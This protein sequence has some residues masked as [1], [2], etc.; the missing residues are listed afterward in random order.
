MALKNLFA[1]GIGFGAPH[2]IVT[3]GFGAEVVPVVVVEELKGG[4]RIYD[5]DD[6]EQK[7]KTRKLR[8]KERDDLDKM[9]AV[10]AVPRYIAP[11]PAP[12]KVTKRV[13]PP[14]VAPEPPALVVPSPDR[15]T[16]AKQFLALD[17]LD[18]FLAE[19]ERTAN[20]NARAVE[21]AH[22]KAKQYARFLEQEQQRIAREALAAEAA[23]RVAEEARIAL[24]ARMVEEARF[25]EIARIQQEQEDELMTMLLM[26][27]HMGVLE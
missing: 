9:L 11:K 10:N 15:V 24:E 26:S 18:D 16:A 27:A 13:A 12:A 8:K 20:E 17:A 4:R 7:V 2:W 19:R 14:V 25:A 1:R 3:H 6:K 22:I 23:A 21:V 5:P